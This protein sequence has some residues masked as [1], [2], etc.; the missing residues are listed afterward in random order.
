MLHSCPASNLPQALS[1]EILRELV[2]VLP[3][4]L[5]D[6]VEL[7]RGSCEGA[8]V[9][10]SCGIVSTMERRPWLCGDCSVCSG[11]CFCM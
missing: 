8:P 10:C 5:D 4:L 1:S 9:R 3:S 2:S 7:M 11:T 6:V